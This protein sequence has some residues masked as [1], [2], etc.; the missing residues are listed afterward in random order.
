M[1][2]EVR[3]ESPLV[4]FLTAD[5]TASRPVEASVELKER[6][7]LGHLNLR[8]NPADHA[9]LDA[10]ERVLG[11]GLLVEPNTVAESGELATLWLGPDEWLVLS[12]PGRETDLAGA[13]HDALGDLFSA[14]TD[15]TGGQTV[16][17]ISGCRARDVLAKGCT[18][19]LHP[20][21]FGP[22]RCAQTLVGKAMITVRQMDDSPS[23]DL[24]VR[25]SFADY[26]ARWL[27]DAA[28]EYGLAVIGP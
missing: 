13:L 28:R 12:P 8:G 4:E 27:E 3:Q 6:A 26:L 22:G 10:V 17:N 11:F 7:F 16:I 18:L 14:V 19:D 9:F 1:S 21:A 2:D 15:V 24:I 23:F 5:R 25:R 20:R